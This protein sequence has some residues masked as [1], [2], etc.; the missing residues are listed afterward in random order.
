MSIPTEYILYTLVAI[1]LILLVWVLRLELRLNRFRV[2]KGAKTIDESLSNISHA[3]SVCNDF[4]NEAE[5][6]LKELDRRVCG[7]VR[8]VSTMRFNPFKGTGS[9]GNQSFATALLNERGDGVVI[10]SLYS[11]DH[12]SVFAKPV[13]QFSSEYELSDEEKEALKNARERLT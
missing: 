1:V 13:K 12:M 9:G 10:S 6:W 7:S 11:R 2:G 4:R 3:L 8:G 5:K